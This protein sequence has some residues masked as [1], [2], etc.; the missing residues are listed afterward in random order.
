MTH[1]RMITNVLKPHKKL[2]KQ[3]RHAEIARWLWKKFSIPGPVF[4][5]TH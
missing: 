3:E 1:A 5:S 4:N 2:T